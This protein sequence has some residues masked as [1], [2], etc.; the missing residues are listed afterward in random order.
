MWKKPFVKGAL[1]YGDDGLAEIEDI[2]KRAAELFSEPE[3]LCRSADTMGSFTAAYY[4]FLTEKIKLDEKNHRADERAGASG[5]LDLAEETSQI[6][7]QIV[8]IFDQIAEI[9]GDESFEGG[10]F[11]EL[12]SAGLSQMEVGVLPPTSDDVLM[13][14]MQRTR[15]GPVKA[16]VVIGANE[17]ILPAGK[18][19]EG[20]FS[21]EE[22]DFSCFGGKR[23]L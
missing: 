10:A 21:M 11:L 2:R 23:N 7:G 8:A 3:Q 18:S 19:S 17:G 9:C 1:E 6:F 22:L 13:G 20:L 16:V 14:T 5:I 12:L 15:S 4:D